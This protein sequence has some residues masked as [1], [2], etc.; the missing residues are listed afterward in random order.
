MKKLICILFL[1]VLIKS[2]VFSQWYYTADFDTSTSL[3]WR[4]DTTQAGNIWQ[5]GPPQKTIFDSA[6]SAPNVIVTDTINPYPINN[7]SS[8]S[9][10]VTNAMVFNFWYITYLIVDFNHKYDTDSLHDGCFI[11]LSTD[12]V[13]WQNIIYFPFLQFVS[14]S[15][16]A[17]DTITGGIP[18]FSGSSNGWQNSQYFFQFC[19][20]PLI[21]DSLMFR[22]TFQSDSANTNKE[23]WMIDNI[24]VFP[25]ICEGIE[26][27]FF[28]SEIVLFPNPASNELLVGGPEFGDK[29]IKLVEIYNVLGEK[30]FTQQPE[31]NSPKQ[32]AIDVSLWKNGMYFA[33][34]KTDNGI[35]RKKFIKQ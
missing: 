17:S 32:V 27:N 13:M 12:G 30:I 14:N 15:Y 4:L 7:R 1:A 10:T 3:P 9:I 5:V 23:G 35:F 19:G 22:F 29:K 20:M 8:F 16:S 34:V 33:R 18:A 28:H 31:V 26:E 11:E 25:N 2:P 24:N 21:I 6:Y